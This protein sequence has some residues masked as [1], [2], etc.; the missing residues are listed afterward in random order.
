MNRLQFLNR[1]VKPNQCDF[2]GR[3][4]STVEAYER[5]KAMNNV[6]P[7]GTIVNVQPGITRLTEDGFVFTPQEAFD[8][9]KGDEG[10]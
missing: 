2:S 5:W 8:D 6:I 10:C 1:W 4:H 3:W 9:R 7:P